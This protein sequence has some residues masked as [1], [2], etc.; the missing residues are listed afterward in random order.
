MHMFGSSDWKSVN[1]GLE[2]VSELIIPCIPKLSAS[3]YEADGVA[4]EEVRDCWCNFL[5]SPLDG[6][7]SVALGNVTIFLHNSELIHTNDV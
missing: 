5:A 1:G 6:R 7:T 4:V 2:L 3:R